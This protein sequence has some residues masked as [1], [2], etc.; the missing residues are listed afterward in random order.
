MVRAR[1]VPYAGHM[2]SA[3][4]GIVGRV[5]SWAR[6]ESGAV[7]T[8]YGLILTLVVLVT[9]VALTLFGASVSGLFDQGTAGFPA[10]GSGS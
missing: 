6:A 5:T 2:K 7:A 9:V 1:R 3:R 8:E 10:G 4:T